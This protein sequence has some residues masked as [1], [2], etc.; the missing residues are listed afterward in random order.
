VFTP[1]Q[2]GTLHETVS[3]PDNA[4]N[5]IGAQQSVAVSGTAKQMAALTSPAPDSTLGSS[6]VTFT[7]TAGFGVQLYSLSVGTNGP[8]ST[9]IFSLGSTEVT[10]ATV[11]SLPTKGMTVYVRLSSRI[12]RV[13]LNVDYVYTE[14]TSVPAALTSPAPGSILGVSNVI[15]GWSAGTFETQYEF[16]LGTGGVGSSNLYNSGWTAATSDAVT[17]VPAKGAKVYARLSSKGSGATQSIDYTYI[18]Q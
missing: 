1:Q 2:P 5:A 12:D 14:G 11:P 9:S 8:G 18:E 10:S 3:L 7:W 16:L 4:S 6:G 15:F 17:S 13:W